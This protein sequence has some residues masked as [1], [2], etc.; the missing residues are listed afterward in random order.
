MSDFPQELDARLLVP[1]G[2]EVRMNL[3][4]IWPHLLLKE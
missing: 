2:A 1:K 4:I 3:V